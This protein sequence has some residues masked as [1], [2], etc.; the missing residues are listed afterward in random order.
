MEVGAVQRQD[1]V[2]AYDAV[3]PRAHVARL[4][5]LLARVRASEGPDEEL[6]HDV[7]WELVDVASGATREIDGRREVN[8]MATAPGAKPIWREP[9][10]YYYG[11][12]EER[13]LLIDSIDRAAELAERVLKGWRWQIYSG[14]GPDNEQ[15]FA[16]IYSRNGAFSARGRS[17]PAALIAAI[18]EAK[19]VGASGDP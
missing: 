1:D 14:G 15:C 9:G 5:R 13:R 16:C 17:E 2:A 6:S 18:I 19:I 12:A 3:E 7:W 8:I 11:D 10:A 4:G